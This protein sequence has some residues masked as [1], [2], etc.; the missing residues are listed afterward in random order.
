MLDDVKT[1]LKEDIVIGVLIFTFLFAGVFGAVNWNN[2]MVPQ[3]P[4]RAVFERE[5]SYQNRM[6]AYEDD[7]ERVGKDAVIPRVWAIPLCVIGLAGAAF[8]TVV[9]VSRHID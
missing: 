3:V 1:Y 9:L 6:S 5:N 8:F 7:K 4:Q 2:H